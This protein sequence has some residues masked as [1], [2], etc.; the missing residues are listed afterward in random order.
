MG[1]N[2]GEVYFKLVGE[3]DPDIVTKELGIEPTRTKQKGSPIP[4]FDSWHYSHGKVIAD[5]IDI[6]EMSS[7][8]VEELNPRAEVI[9]E[10]VRKHKLMAELQVV[11][12]IT[13]NEEISTPAIGFEQNVI[14]F[15][16]KV[17]ASIDI[18][19]YRN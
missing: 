19:T 15:L 6:Y 12:W 4:K 2:E 16:S 11:L 7:K 5:F 3:F 18:D 14:Q 9:A 1:T 17:G 8:L 13:M 10:V